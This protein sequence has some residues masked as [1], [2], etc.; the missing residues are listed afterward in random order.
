[1]EKFFNLSVANII[2]QGNNLTFYLNRPNKRGWGV[3]YARLSIGGKLLRLSTSVRVRVDFWSIRE[4]RVIIPR[5]ATELEIALHTIAERHL[6]EIRD[7]VETNYFD[8]LCSANALISSSV[9]FDDIKRKLNQ[10]I[11]SKIMPKMKIKPLMTLLREIVGV[12][13]NLKTQRNLNGILTNFETFLNAKG[14]ANSVESVNMV[15][16]RRYREWLVTESGV[17]ASRGKHC[18]NYLFTLC[19]R[20]ERRDGFDFQLD[21]NKIEPIKDPR[22]PEER[23]LNGIALTDEEI[24]R[25]EALE[26]DGALEA[27]RDMFLLQCYCGF[28]FEDMGLL[29]KTSNVQEIGGIK[30]SVFETQKKDIISHTPLNNPKL[31][32]EVWSIF[33]RYADKCPYTD[34]DGNKY[35]KQIK[36]LARLAGLDREVTIT[37]TKGESKHKKVVKVYNEI[38]SHDLRHTFITNAIRYKGLTPNVLIYITGHSDTKMIETLYANLQGVDKMNALNKALNTPTKGNTNQQTK[39]DEDDSMPLNNPANWSGLEFAKWLVKE[40]GYPFDVDTLQLGQL[41]EVIERG[42]NDIIERYGVETFDN[43]ERLFKLN[44]VV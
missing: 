28:R 3:I 39:G 40:M 9:M 42:K 33:E 25:V 14:I 31:Y 17:G 36:T 27:A 23:R 34:T 22:T 29:L 43:I 35:N 30:F 19:N 38:T 10:L 12:M 13:P 41:W 16:F 5:S 8:Y 20:L 18:I 6:V 1:M 24:K 2:N 44:G 26:V 21:R 4:G 32:P 37:T 7:F 15:T 11:A